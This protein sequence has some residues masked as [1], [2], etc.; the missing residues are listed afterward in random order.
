MR[1]GRKRRRLRLRAQPPISYERPEDSSFHAVS[2][3]LHL[4]VHVTPFARLDLDRY[5]PPPPCLH[6]PVDSAPRTRHGH[7]HSDTS[8][9]VSINNSSMTFCCRR[10]TSF[11][12]KNGSINSAR[13][14]FSRTILFSLLNSFLSVLRRF[15]RFLFLLQP[16][17]RMTT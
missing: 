4:S 16:H 13:F 17:P 15:F 6:G 14:S 12:G 7:R 3:N 8:S 9:L 1:T 10:S 5:P 11:R 2:R